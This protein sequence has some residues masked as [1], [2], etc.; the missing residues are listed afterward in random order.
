VTSR[1]RTNPDFVAIAKFLEG[2]ERTG[3]PPTSR[4]STSAR[5]G[6]PDGY[7]VEVGVSP[8]D[9][10]ETPSRASSGVTGD[11]EVVHEYKLFV[12][13]NTEVAGTFMRSSTFLAGKGVPK[14]RAPDAVIRK[15]HSG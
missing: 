12:G 2:L 14:E 15:S 9:R 10:N 6:E 8:Y 3:A 7:G 11:V 5:T 4:D 1:V 13:R